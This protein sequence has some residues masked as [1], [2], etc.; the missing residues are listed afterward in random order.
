MVNWESWLQRPLQAILEV[1]HCLS[2]E[3][4]RAGKPHSARADV[5][6]SSRAKSQ[7]RSV[8]YKV[9]EDQSLLGLCRHIEATI[10]AAIRC[11]RPKAESHRT[12]VTVPF[13][14]YP[15]MQKRFGKPLVLILANTMHHRASSP[16]RFAQPDRRFSPRD[17]SR[18]VCAC[19]RAA[20]KDPRSRSARR[21]VQQEKRRAADRSGMW[22][23][24]S[25]F[26]TFRKSSGS[27]DRRH[28][29]E[30]G[31]VLAREVR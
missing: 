5:C 6:A 30:S 13:C 22:R 9:A 23:F 4:D 11:Q 28:V 25:H 26:P 2:T 10:H 17:D 24:L 7:W 19:H 1:N 20:W 21:A 31:V 27:A 16:F 14:L 8:H 15:G 12:T 18:P 29:C 3:D